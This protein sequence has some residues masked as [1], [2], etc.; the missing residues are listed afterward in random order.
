MDKDL[1][2]VVEVLSYEEDDDLKVEIVEKEKEVVYDF[3]ELFIFE[4]FCVMLI[5]KFLKC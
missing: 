4:G 3:M 1:G 2:D 5:F